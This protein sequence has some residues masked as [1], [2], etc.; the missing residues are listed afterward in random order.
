M[1]EEYPNWFETPNAINAFVM[2]MDR[3]YGK[4]NLRF[5]QIGAYLGHATEWIVKSV[6]TGKDCRIIDVDTWGGSEETWHGVINFNDVEVQYDER[7]STLPAVTKWKMTSDEALD[8]CNEL[9]LLFDFIYI[10]GAHTAAQVRKDWRGSWPLL[11][12]GGILAFDDYLWT[13]PNVDD[14][15]NTPKPAIDEFL[16]IHRGEYDVLLSAWQVWVVK[17]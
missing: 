5:L 13:D 11:R 3:F 14:P 7:V 1:T 16:N 10:D 8:R 12:S 9:G 4:N 6:F 15:E 17:K 2:N